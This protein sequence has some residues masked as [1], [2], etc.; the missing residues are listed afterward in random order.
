[1]MKT[2]RTSS[3]LLLLVLLTGLCAADWLGLFTGIDT[4]LYDLVFRLRGQRPIAERVVIAAIDEKTLATFGKWPIQRTV[5]ASLL[6]KVEGA[7]A[8]GFDVV[9]SEPSSDDSAVA[10]ALQRHGRVVLPVYLDRMLEPTLPVPAFSFAATGHVHFEQG[11][12]HVAREVFHTIT[13]GDWQITSLASALLR[14]AT[15]VPT[16]VPEAGPSGESVHQQNCHRINFYGPPGTFPHLS[17]AEIVAGRYPAGF[18]NGKIILVGLTAPGIIDLVSTPFSEDRNGM[19]GVELH[20]NI[21]NNLL[22]DNRIRQ[23]PDWLRFAVAALFALPIWF[24]SGK[25]GETRAF[26]TVAI[27][28][29]L[30]SAGCFSLFAAADLWLAPS[31]LYASL[32]LSFIV[33]HLRQLDETA[34]RLEKEHQAIAALIYGSRAVHT[35]AAGGGLLALLTRKGIN[36]N[37]DRLVELQRIYADNLQAAVECRTRQLEEALSTIASMSDEMVLRLAWAV[38]SKDK[39]TSE[40]TFRLGLY[41][42]LI[43]EKLGLPEDFIDS[44]AFASALHD[45]G[46]IGIPDSILLKKGPLNQEEMEIIKT[47]CLIGMRI[48][49]KSSF[50]KIRMCASIAL[51]HHERWD[52]TGYPNGLKGEEIPL[53]ARIIAVCDC[54]DSLRSSR[55]YKKAYDHETTLRIMLEGN[56]RTSPEHFDPVVLQAFRKIAPRLADIF[57]EHQD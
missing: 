27:L 43:S 12:D 35:G 53:E 7:A 45:V 30:L 19:S 25:T 10:L 54:Y 39:D 34:S 42:R 37:I 26:I 18:F 14:M 2:S 51:N 29:L 49:D 40:H 36:R 47:H 20:A 17:V 4:W 23:V 46:K 48:L 52:G 6:S 31:L 13:G 21:L 3:L 1:M 55:P 57:S 38:E 50:P 11:V 56:S 33:C 28:L 15:G 5:Y 41:A 9:L 8:V 22:D 16:T 44:I 24:I 32:S